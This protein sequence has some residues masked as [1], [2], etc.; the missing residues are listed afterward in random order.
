MASITSLIGPGVNAVKAA[1]QPEPTLSRVPTR[2]QREDDQLAQWN[3]MLRAKGMPVNEVYEDVMFK[4]LWNSFKHTPT[5]VVGGGL[6][7]AKQFIGAYWNT[8]KENT[9]N[10]RLSFKDVNN[11]YV[12]AWGDAA[13]KAMNIG[14]AGY[15]DRLNQL[16]E[17]NKDEKAT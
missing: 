10:E 6:E 11:P 3:N 2:A 14:T 9:T 1:N 8:I 12:G 13:V 7:L 4:S 16:W 5:T 17:E 15:A